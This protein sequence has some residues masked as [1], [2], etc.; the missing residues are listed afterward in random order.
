VT[1]AADPAGSEVRG[2][3]GYR[4]DIDGLRA[5]AV[6]LIVLY[7]IGFAGLPGGYVGVDVFFVISG[8][9]ITGLLI[10]ELDQTGTLSLREFYARRARRILP[11]SFLV[12]LVTLVLCF[13][14]FSPVGF[15]HAAPDIAAAAGYIPNLL[16]ARQVVDYF[17]PARISPVI[18]YWSLGVEEQFYVIYP[19]FLLMAH[20]IAARRGPRTAA[21]VVLATAVSLGLS[22]VLTPG[23]PTAAFYLLPTRAW[24]L[25]A[26]AMLAFAGRRFG[27]ARPVL[28]NGAGLLGLALIAG[29]A[30]LFQSTVEFPGVAALVPV[31]GAVLVIASGGA[32]R[33]PWSATLLSLAPMRYIG[34]IS[35]SMYLWHWPLI[36]F[37]AIALN[38]VIPDDA[39]GAVAVGLTL[40]LAASTYRWI[41]DPMRHGR[42]VGRRPSRNLLTALAA[43]IVIAVLA[44][45]GAHLAVARFEPATR[46]VPSAAT[47]PLAGLLPATGP[48]QDGPLPRNLTPSLLNLHAGPSLHNPIAA[49]CS[50]L[51]GETVN[52]PCTYGDPTS[53]TEVVLFGDSHLN[54]WWPALEAIMAERDWKVMIL[55]KTS[56][57]YADVTTMENGGLRLECDTWRRLA[58][59]RIVADR[60]AFV[61]LSANHRHQ[62]AVNGVGLDGAAGIAAMQAGVSRTI[63][64][65]SSAGARVV[66]LG[67]TSQVPW[68]P[69]DCLSSNANHILRCAVPRDAALDPSW[70]AAEQAATEALGATFVDT[71]AWICPSDPCPAV[72]GPF[73]VYADTNHL[74]R[75]FVAALTSRLQ[76]A[77]PR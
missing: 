73:V 39:Q 4:P 46:P 55:I 36:V 2:A 40:V 44:L 67:D 27:G 47:D 30:L 28:A 5:I 45:G 12:L 68:D 69:A 10:R 32:S 7:H 24:E 31:A 23:H 58:L 65:L 11:A 35:Y 1:A 66:V 15:W 50:L 37:G 29:S 18:H 75:P 57:P 17:H 19:A 13:V 14:L 74:T 59:A 77:I 60:P 6:G 21:Y 56:C 20:R 25:G 72:I 16:F 8:V 76:A 43:S 52:G 38:G 51:A 71:A 3:L 54:Q 34:R 42:F 33:V 26:G 48:T 49:G 9:L 62:A 22:V 64:T 61:I 70:L 41:E 63:A 53:K